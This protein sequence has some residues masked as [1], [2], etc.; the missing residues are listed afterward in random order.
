MTYVIRFFRDNEYSHSLER[1]SVDFDSLV[2]LAENTARQHNLSYMIFRKR[3]TLG[4][5]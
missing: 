1:F 2:T 3:S 5:A 4:D